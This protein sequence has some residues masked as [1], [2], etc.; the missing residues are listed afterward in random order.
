M[1]ALI[2]LHC[3]CA[4]NGPRQR[5]VEFETGGDCGIEPTFAILRQTALQERANPDRHAVGQRAPVGF[6]REDATPASRQRPR[7]QT[8]APVS[9]SKSTHPNAQMSLRLSAGRPLACSGLMYAAV[10]M[11]KPTP[12]SSPGS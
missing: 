11:I 8:G 12:V 1:A 9:I 10:P 4:R 7:R 5:I 6:L 3:R 2:L